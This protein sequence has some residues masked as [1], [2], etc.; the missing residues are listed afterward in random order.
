MEI[1]HL[2][3]DVIFKMFFADEKNSDIL[4]HF[5]QAVLDLPDGELTD[6]TIL[7]PTLPKEK[8]KEKDLIIDVRAK[9][10]SGDSFHIEI[11]SKAYKFF[12]ERIA[13]YNAKT[14]GSQLKSD[15]EY[16]KLQKTISIIIVGSILFPEEKEYHQSFTYRSKKGLEFTDFQQIH[17]LE[18]KKVPENS[19][20]EKDLWMRLLKAKKNGEVEGLA[21]QSQVLEKAVVRLKEL[22]AD[23]KAQMLAQQ[24]EDSLALLAT[25]ED[26]AKEE[27]RDEGREEEKIKIAKKMLAANSEIDFIMSITGL[28]KDEIL[29]IY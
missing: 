7:N 15:I 16:D 14:F 23:E 10:K 21:R 8:F 18:L 4:L 5:L 25:I 9:K 3:N 27:G 28:S 19:S 22:S 13:Y 26:G 24:R 6:V 29:G 11:Q 12:K 17:T 1:L 2:A 20:K